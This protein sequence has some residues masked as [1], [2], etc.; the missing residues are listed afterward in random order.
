[1]LNDPGGG[2]GE[3][4]D[5]EEFFEDCQRIVRDHDGIFQACSRILG[6]LFRILEVYSGSMNIIQDFKRLF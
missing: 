1:M 3:Q 4:R 5:F 6:R 2:E